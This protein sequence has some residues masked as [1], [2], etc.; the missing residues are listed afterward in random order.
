MLTSDTKYSLV[1]P[2]LASAPMP[3]GLRWPHR[4]NNETW[5]AL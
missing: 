5:V 2:V 1:L 4:R 3:P